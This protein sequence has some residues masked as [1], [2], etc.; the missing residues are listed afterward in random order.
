M[1]ISTPPEQKRPPIFIVLSFAAC[2]P[3]MSVFPSF[4]SVVS[5]FIRLTIAVNSRVFFNIL[6][7]V[8]GVAFRDYAA[9]AG[10]HAPRTRLLDLSAQFPSKSRFP[11]AIFS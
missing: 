9:R 1:P 4:Y 8:P 11:F 5:V 3:S 6:Y 7:G 10:M 2:S